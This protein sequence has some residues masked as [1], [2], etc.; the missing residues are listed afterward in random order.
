MNKWYKLT[1]TDVNAN[2]IILKITFVLFFF[3][4]LTSLLS[5]NLVAM[6]LWTIQSWLTYVDNYLYSPKYFIAILFTNIELISV[7]VYFC[8]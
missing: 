8:N 6:K 2:V 5:S 3:F 1:K 7:L 4:M